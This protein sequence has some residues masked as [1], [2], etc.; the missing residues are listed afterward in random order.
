MIRR[1]LIAGIALFVIAGCGSGADSDSP[2]PLY[3]AL[4]VR[5][6]GLEVGVATGK[7]NQDVADALAL[8]QCGTNCVVKLRFTNGQCASSAYSTGAGIMAWGL[9]STIDQATDNAKLSCIQGGGTFCS[10]YRGGCN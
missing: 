7:S 8:D 9:G 3:G 10:Q 2:P 5:Q 4:A 1:I 6:G